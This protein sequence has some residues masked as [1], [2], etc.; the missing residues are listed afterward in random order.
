LVNRWFIDNTYLFLILI[1]IL[2]LLFF[3]FT[4]YYFILEL[5]KK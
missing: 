4:K 5:R 1:L 2:I 3:I